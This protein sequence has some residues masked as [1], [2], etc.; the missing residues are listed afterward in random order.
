MIKSLSGTIFSLAWKTSL[1]ILFFLF[2][3]LG[4]KLK[5]KVIIKDS[6]SYQINVR[7]SRYLT[8]KFFISLIVGTLTGLILFILKIDFAIMFGFLAFLLNFIP[9]IGSVFAILLPVPVALL[10]YGIDFHTFLTLLLPS[11]IQFTLGNI[12]EPK[13]Q[14]ESLGL[15]PVTVLLSLLLWGFLWGFPGMF[16]AVPLTA[17]LKIILE[18]YELTN[19][20][21][22]F[23]AGEI[24]Q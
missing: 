4:T 3:T 6:M 12:V 15:H 16:I 14:G 24:E 21:A 17:V 22:K 5:K 20:F 19:I 23:L 13:I 8:I 9:S 2:L 7:V 1:V 18:R 10:K 11:V